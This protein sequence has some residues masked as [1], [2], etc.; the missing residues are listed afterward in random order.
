MPPLALALVSI[1]LWSTV[2]WLSLKLAH[3]PPFLLV[4]ICLL[5]G[6]LCGAARLR[7]WRAATPRLMALGVYGLFGFHFFLFT[8]LRHAPPIEANLINYLWP[9]LIVVLA[10]VIV[11]ATS[12]T[13]RHV[14]AALIGFG[15][16]ALLAT[17]GRFSVEVAHLFGYGCALASA[18]IWS[19]YSLLTRRMPA[20]PTGT[21][22]AFCAVSGLLS[23]LCHLL[24]E[25]TPAIAA[26]DWFWMAAIGVGPLGVAFFTWDA[27]M[28]R[29]DPRVIG[30][31]SYL[32][33][34]LSTLWLA[35]SGAGTLGPLALGAMA[36]IVG[37]A[38]LGSTPARA[39]KGRLV[40]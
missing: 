2:A 1:L 30:T 13:A 9:L 18:V 33:P 10:P 19:T 32:T 20:F 5:V 35:F 15:G 29:G 8:A 17:G 38:V 40:E 25:S 12:L 24:W 34:L 26:S 36:A 27:A 39:A 6:A 23:L 3:I 22:G 31:L 16:A 21:V 37:G 11:P 28:K 4:G 14:A 7:D